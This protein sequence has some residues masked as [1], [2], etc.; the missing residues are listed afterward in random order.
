MY[1]NDMDWCLLY[2]E[3]NGDWKI[4]KDTDKDF[5]NRPQHSDGTE[6]T[7]EEINKPSDNKIDIKKNEPINIL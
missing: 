1:C 4:G 5:M 2:C 7:D 3:S 6:Y